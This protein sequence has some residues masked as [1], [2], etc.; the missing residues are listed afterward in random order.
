MKAKLMKL[1]QDSRRE[2]SDFIRLVLEDTIKKK[3]KV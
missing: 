1:A 2:M 3:I